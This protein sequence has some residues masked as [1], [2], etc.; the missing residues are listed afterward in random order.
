V[1]VTG[2]TVR[3]AGGLVCRNGNDGAVEIVLVHRPAYDDWAFPKGKLQRGESEPDAALREVEE[4]TGLRCSLGRE[5]GTT[6]YNDS[7]GRPKTV[8]Y[9][10]MAP[11][12]GD[13]A[14]TSE[15]DK[16]RWIAL[17][18][19]PGELTYARDRELLRDLQA[20]ARRPPSS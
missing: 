4:E 15:I 19:A 17:A 6:A 20:Q 12:A 8:R 10:E 1:D 5:V 3:A 16:A 2:Q 14:P 13:L 9:W 7:R 18:D 11:L